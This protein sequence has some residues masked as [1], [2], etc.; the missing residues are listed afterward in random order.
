MT[1]SIGGGEDIN[2][3]GECAL[4]GRRHL[5]NNKEKEGG[6]GEGEI[7]HGFGDKEGA[8]EHHQRANC[9]MWEGRVVGNR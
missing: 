8:A 9:G 6:G 4:P 3:G 5:E 2:I 7:A 1:H